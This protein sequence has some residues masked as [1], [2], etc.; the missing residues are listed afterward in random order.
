MLAR[1]REIYN[2]TLD[3]GFI[4]SAKGPWD[5]LNPMKKILDSQTVN[6][7]RLEGDEVAAI[8]EVLGPSWAALR[9]L[10]EGERSSSHPSG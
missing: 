2:P 3:D 6:A 5:S 9:S 4:L 10:A 7:R 8:A 1:G